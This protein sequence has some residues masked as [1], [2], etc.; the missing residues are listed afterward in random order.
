MRE[1]GRLAAI[2]RLAGGVAHEVRNPLSSIKGLAL[3]LK[4][5]FAE[6]SRERDTAD[7]LIQETERMNRTITEMLSFTRPAALRLGPVDMAAL[8]RRC[9]ELVKAEAADGG[10]VT[11]LAV[12]DDLPTVQADADRLQQVL[13]NVLLNGLQAMDQGG[14]L[15]VTAAPAES[16]QAVEIRI[17][18]T[19]K[20]IPPEL[21]SQVFFPYFTTRQGG[22]GIGLAISQK[23]VTD[24]QGTIEVESEVGQGTTVIIRLPLRQPETAARPEN[25]AVGDPV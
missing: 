3:L 7:L 23:I 19:G 8:L 15:S 21:L 1:S 12:P 9:L 24:H 18:D 14:R 20:G 11:K 22:S 4:N 17:A 2:S 16:S 25:V 5:K 10:V 13:M 6:G